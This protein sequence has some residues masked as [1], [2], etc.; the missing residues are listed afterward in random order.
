MKTAYLM[1]FEANDAF[2]LTCLQLDT[3]VRFSSLMY[4]GDQLLLADC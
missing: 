4:S 2:L 1:Q 3:L